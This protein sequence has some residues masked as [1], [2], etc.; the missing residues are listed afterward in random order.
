MIRCVFNNP[1]IERYELYFTP[2]KSVEPIPLRLIR[3][4]HIGH[5][6]KTRGIVIRASELMPQLVVATYVC[7]RLEE[8]CF[9]FCGFEWFHSI[10]ALPRFIRKWQPR[11]TCQKPN[12]R[13]ECAKA[14]LR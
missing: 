13:V 8:I 11:F 10:D 1:Q 2:R 12:A 7:D 6:V 14:K 3:S 5:L 4:A 9:C